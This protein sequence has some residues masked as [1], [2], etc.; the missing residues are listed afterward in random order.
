MGPGN[1][2][3]P[4]TNPNGSA[5]TGQLRYVSV[6]GPVANVPTQPDCSDAVV[7][8][9]PWDTNR[10]R[11][12]P[13]G[14]VNKLMGSMPQPNNYEVGDGLNTAGNR[15]VR[16]EKNGNESIFSLDDEGL[17]RPDNLA[18]KQINL[19][20]DH[21]FN[22]SHKVSGTYTYEYSN[23]V[24]NFEPW[25]DRFPRA[26]L[27]QAATSCAEFHVHTVAKPGQ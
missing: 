17:N 2:L 14:F 16:R 8:G 26:T 12:D 11:V 25:P 19:K 10:T 9:S 3:R 15:W 27:P 18:R 23:G 4:A 22:P 20:I 13:T 1:P 7:Q 5:F 24:A 21:N 6:F